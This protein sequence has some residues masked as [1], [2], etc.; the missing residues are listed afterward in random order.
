MILINQFFLK[1][2]FRYLKKKPSSMS[3]VSQIYV[4]PLQ[5]QNFQGYQ[6]VPQVSGFLILMMRLRSMGVAIITASHSVLLIVVS[7]S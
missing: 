7:R 2:L 4:A 1:V 3:R 5:W 6:I